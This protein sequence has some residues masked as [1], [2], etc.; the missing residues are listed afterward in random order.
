MLQPPVGELRIV[1]VAPAAHWIPQDP[2]RAGLDH[3]SGHG[4]AVVDE[5][6]D[7][8][9]P[10]DAQFPMVHWPPVPHAAMQQ[11]PEVQEPRVHTVLAPSQV[12][13]QPPGHASMAQVLPAPHALT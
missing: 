7:L 2:R 11:P 3:A 6:S 9:V 4:W 8:A 5:A 12:S 13:M 1:Q 10:D